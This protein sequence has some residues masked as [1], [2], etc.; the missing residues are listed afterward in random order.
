MDLHNKINIKY[1]LALLIAII[2]I[3]LFCV[4]LK[5]KYF[6]LSFFDFVG[7]WQ[8]TAYAYQGIDPYPLIG[9]NSANITSIGAIPKG[10][11]TA[12][13]GLLLGNLFYPGFMS[14]KNAKIYFVVFNF[15]LLCITA[16]GVFRKFKQLSVQVGSYSFFC[17]LFSFWFFYSLSEGNAGGGICCLLLLVIIYYDKHPVFTGL[18]LGLSLIKPQLSLI[19]CIAFLFLKNYKVVFVSFGVVALSSLIVSIM[20]HNNIFNLIYEFLNAGIGGNVNY[21]GIFTLFFV[22]NPILAMI[23]SMMTGII[24]VAVFIHFLPKDLLKPFCLLPASIAA[25]F[26]SYSFLNDFYILLLPLIVSIYSVL[27]VNNKWLSVVSFFGALYMST[28]S[29]IMFYNP[30]L[31]YKFLNFLNISIQLTYNWLLDV[32]FVRTMFEM[33][34]IIWAFLQCYLLKR[35]DFD[36]NL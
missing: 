13:W 7:Q 2:N 26:W 30:F 24:F 22:G 23:I 29:F 5:G 4:G 32:W 20:V 14:L 8:L 33:G 9:S 25:T 11:G 27:N 10:W 15:F 21:S 12:P 19:I 35:I 1:V 3:C 34:L 31:F 36:K 18:L 17:A 16:L 6:S 28:G